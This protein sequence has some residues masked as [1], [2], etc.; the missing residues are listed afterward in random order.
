MAPDVSSPSGMCPL[1]GANTTP[2]ANYCVACGQPL[3]PRPALRSLGPVRIVEAEAPDASD[4][5]ASAEMAL[6]TRGEHS[7]ALAGRIA[8]LA[9]VAWRQPVVRSAV[10]T[11]AS[12][13]ALSLV[14]RV[15]GA[16]LTGGKARRAL[17][18]ELADGSLSPV[19]GELLRGAAPGKRLR[20]RGRRGEIVEEVVYIRRVFRR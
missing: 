8:S 19:A 6:A 11:G 12:A 5:S 15:A 10:T 18:S 17:L 4:S 7:S 2:D 13:V 16:A 1:C 3:Q 14:W 20:R 9:A